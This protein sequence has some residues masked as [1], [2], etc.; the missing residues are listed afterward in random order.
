VNSSTHT[1]ALKAPK[2][3]VF[4]FLSRIENLPRWA[5]LFCKEL[6]R[7]EDGRYKV[8][9]PG[10][11]ILFKIEADPISGV[12]DMRGGPCEEQLAF[13]PARVVECGA[14]SLFIFTAFQY[15]GVSDAE[16]AAQCEGLE[17]EFP[18]IA[19]HTD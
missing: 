15:P 5:T 4:E 13:W 19:A 18:N 11:E 14:G 17:R 6:K 8:V 16:F 10:G 3:R 12:I 7:L 1:F 2:E 9:T